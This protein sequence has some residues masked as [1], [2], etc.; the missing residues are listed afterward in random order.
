MATAFNPTV[1]YGL[2]DVSR[3]DLFSP[4]SRSGSEKSRRTSD[5]G[6]TE[7]VAACQ[8]GDPDALR[9]LYYAC[10]ESVFRL[11]VRMVGLQEAADVTQQV[12]LQAIRSIGK[13]R[14]HSQFK[15][16]LYRLT[17][18]ESLQH[19]RRNRRWRYQALDWETIDESHA[20]GDAERKEMLE[21][22]LA[23]I[24][25]ELRSI[26]VLRE[27]EG[28]SYHEIGEVLQI[29]GGTVGSRL[30]RARRELRRHLSDLGPQA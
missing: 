18:N 30:N 1:R 10:H 19:L 15:T 9:R 26:F 11:T 8:K 3:R 12:F 16:W 20:G 6:L 25:P 2:P 24:D 13:F 23:R 14:G 21:Q 22:S 5:D 7:V 27:V 29:P 28:M 17:V 4:L